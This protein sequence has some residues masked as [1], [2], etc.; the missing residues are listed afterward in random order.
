MPTTGIS[1]ITLADEAYADAKGY[2]IKLLCRVIAGEDGAV[3]PFVEPHLVSLQDPLGGVED[4]FNAIKVKGDAVGDVMFY[5]RGAGKLPTA[6]AVVADVIAAARK[7][8]RAS[9]HPWQPNRPECVQ[10]PDTFV[11]PWYVRLAEGELAEG[12]KLDAVGPQAGESGWFTSPMTRPELE[13]L[14]AGKAVLSVIR[15]LD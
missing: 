2:R 9:Y 8:E 11:S 5:G 10:H 1:K 4:V 15:I 12:E 7:L 6:S 3:C 14:L 13:K